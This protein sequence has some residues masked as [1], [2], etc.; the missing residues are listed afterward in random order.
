M[1]GLQTTPAGL[2]V[3][4][5]VVRGPC[6]RCCNQGPCGYGQP[7][8]CIN[9]P[10]R[11]PGCTPY[12]GGSGPC[13]PRLDR[14]D[15]GVFSQIIYPPNRGGCCGPVAGRTYTVEREEVT[16][17]SIGWPTTFGIRGWVRLNAAGTPDAG[18]FI[19]YTRETFDGATGTTTTD[20]GLLRV[21][22]PGDPS[23]Y[24][25]RGSGVPQFPNP[26]WPRCDAIDL[27]GDPPGT[28]TYTCT[29]IQGR[30][31]FD[32]YHE[33]LDVWSEIRLTT[34]SIP[35]PGIVQALSHAKSRLTV[36]PNNST[37]QTPGCPPRGACCCGGLCFNVT[38]AECAAQRGRYL[39][40]HTTCYGNTCS[41][42]G[43]CCI[44]DDCADTDRGTCY[45]MGGVW[46]GAGTSC[47]RNDPNHQTPGNGPCSTAPAKCCLPSG[48]CINTSPASCVAQ[49]GT[50]YAGQ[51]CGQ[52]GPCQVQS[53]GA[54]C[55]PAGGCDQINVTQCAAA[56]GVWQGE[57]SDCGGA[58]GQACLT[59]ACCIPT[60]HGIVCDDTHTAASCAVA[61]GTYHGN[62]SSCSTNPCGIRGAGKLWTPA[63]RSSRIVVPTS[64]GYGTGGCGSCPGNA[65]YQVF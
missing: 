31:F 3:H 61:I 55:M 24:V 11:P 2:Y 36:G 62:G 58:G 37:C 8:C 51:V 40:D 46:G 47:R 26:G 53:T 41:P 25:T 19:P 12:G 48:V 44:G 32:C 49:G 57:G 43:R 35:P 20:A 14:W 42:Q 16:Y 34:A 50:P 39:G 45:Q 33:D 27:I 1:P 63:S 30:R 18:G 4:G 64:Y 23:C 60:S 65:G 21:T 17:N 5:G 15:N 9:G 7:S 56:G 10:T 13:Q 28:G 29:R 52:G 38:Q 59:G 54:C 22:L 6:P